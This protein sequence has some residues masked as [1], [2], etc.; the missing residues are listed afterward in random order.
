VP[1]V[2]DETRDADARVP[3]EFLGVQWTRLP[4]GGTPP[5]FAQRVRQLLG[6]DNGGTRTSQSAV[7]GKIEPGAQRV[8]SVRPRS[9]SRVRPVGLTLIVLSLILGGGLF[10]R[11]QNATDTP[12]APPAPATAASVAIA[13]PNERS[14]AVLPFVDMSAEKNQEYMSDGIA[15]ELLNLLAKIPQLRVISRSS[16]FS[17][18]GQNLDIPEIGK[19]L[20]VAHILEGSVRKSGN[21]L[22]ITAQ[23]IDA[24]SDLHQWSE[25][26]DRT[27]DNIFAVQDEIAAAV[28]AQLKLKLL[29]AA[30]KTQ[31]TDPKAYTLYL[32]ARQ[33]SGQVTREGYEQSIALYKQ[34]LAIDP[35]YVAAWNELAHSYTQ[36]GEEGLRPSNEAY[37]LARE[38]AGKALSIDPD[39][40]PAYAT[41]GLIAHTYDGDLKAAAGHIEHAL[42][43]QPN[44][45]NEAASLA[46]SLGRCDTAITMYE[47]MLAR[48]PVN[49]GSHHNEGYA[50]LCAGRLDDAI[51]SLRTAVSMAPGSAG[52][53]MHLGVALLEKGDYPA[54]LAAIE[55]EPA[56][57]WRM[58]GLPMAYY[59]LGRQAES[60]AALAELIRK[61]EK[62]AAY[63]IA[64][65]LAYRGESDRAFE[66]LSKAI[67]YHDPGVSE[68]NIDPL[69][70]KLRKDSRW[71]P[72]L[73]KI[74]KAPEQL[75][76][77]KF[78]VKL[79]K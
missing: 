23:L 56:E 48:D 62:D 44:S 16:A 58:I 46:L 2:I 53:H 17:F 66:W 5:A 38:A 4:G 74:G 51:A 75:A 13:A 12:A 76:A 40:A 65:V 24:R 68:V 63:N 61:Y 42:A 59:A 9:R 34:A 69:L 64:Q 29:G 72:F 54:A 49:V 47:F 30:P 35:S 1:V 43:L 78:D 31:A 18:K 37:R 52:F 71:L 7:T 70:A 28:V 45:I 25:T 11:Y 8:I 22:R 21:K 36:Q 3:E 32:Q 19:R 10:W 67:I 15:E 39:Y 41:L 33:L 14:I 20:N 77:I 27:L 79:P 55:K 50:Y 57:G 73:R 26:Y 60:D 6:T